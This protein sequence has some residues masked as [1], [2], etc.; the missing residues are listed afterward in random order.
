MDWIEVNVRVP[1]EREA[2]VVDALTPLCAGVAVETAGGFIADATGSP[3]PGSD[4]VEA[5]K[6]VTIKAYFSQ[7]EDAMSGAEAARSVLGLAG[8]SH[9][10]ELRLLPES[11]WATLWRRYF[12]IQRVSPTM[13]IVPSWRSYKARPGERVLG[14]DPGLAFGT[15]QHATTRLC[16]AAIERHVH[17]GDRCWTWV[18]ARAFCRSR[19]RSAGQAK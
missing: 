11:D 17:S 15:G 10:V 12:R 7:E 8:P 18:R 6:L 14:L 16:L 1:P 3:E 13:V 5:N 9:D 2:A 19:R 4:G